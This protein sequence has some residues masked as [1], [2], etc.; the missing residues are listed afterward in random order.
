MGLKIASTWPEF[1]YPID[2]KMRGP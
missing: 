1:A 2:T